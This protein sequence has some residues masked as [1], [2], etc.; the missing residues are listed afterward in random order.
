MLQKKYKFRARE[1]VLYYW[2]AKGDHFRA[3]VL[4]TIEFNEANPDLNRYQI[5]ILNY[6]KNDWLLSVQEESLSPIENPNKLMKDLIH[7]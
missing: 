3:V 6:Q 1:E 5:R 7:V 2:P 4:K